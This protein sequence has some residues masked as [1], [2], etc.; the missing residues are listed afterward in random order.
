MFK[1]HMELRGAKKVENYTISYL[2]QTKDDICSADA[3][4]NSESN[5]YLSNGR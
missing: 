4:I 1:V 2:Y 5:C 3:D